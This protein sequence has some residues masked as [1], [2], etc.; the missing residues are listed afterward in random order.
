[1]IDQNPFGGQMVSKYSRKIFGFALSKTAHEHNAQDLAQEILLALHRSLRT[2]KQV[3]NM[4][5]W[6]HTIC[7]YTW[8]NY[9][10]KEKRHWH[11]AD[12]DH[13]MQI[14]DDTAESF[15][16]G[17]DP[18][19]EKLR[20]EIAYLSRL[21]REMTVRYYYDR[22]SI[23]QIAEQMKLATGTVKWHLFEARKKLKEAL[24]LEST[25]EQLS[26]KPIKLMVGHSGTPG[27]NNEPNCYFHSLLTG[28]VCAAIYD[29]ALSIE[30]LARKLGA[31]SAY[32]EDEV[33]KLMKSD[34]I[35]ESGKGKYRTNF[36]IQTM[37]TRRIEGLYFKGKAEE[38]ADGLH[39]CVA[40]VLGEIRATGFHG[41]Q[42]SDN[43]LL[44]T[45]L[46][47]A[48]WKQYLQ[49]QEP[50]YYERI[51]PDERKDGGKYIVDASI[52]YTDDEYRRALT[53]Y[54]IVRKYATNGI[55]SR[56]NDLYGGL[57]MEHWW[58]GLIWRDF[59]SPD[60]TDMGQAVELIDNNAIHTDHDRML[61]SR[62]VKKGFVGME[63]GKLECLVPFFRAEQLDKLHAILE[64][65]FDN[66]G[67][68]QQMN[69]IH[70]DMKAISSQEA[71]SFV[72]KKDV[73]YHA[74]NSGM[75][76]IF[77]VMEYLTRT[78]KIALPEESE[79]NRLTTL[80]W[81]KA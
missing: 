29:K 53:D 52:V 78:G 7:C 63:Q 42:L 64:E 54:E 80:I 3:D 59:D 57:Q 27:P 8:S 31:A 26:F 76:I 74:T 30:D 37:R 65:S 81:R 22:Q 68:K 6:V 24:K 17:K 66:A 40:G 48:I 9:V 41:G 15:M 2:S 18:I 51:S 71:P 4:D 14:R 38:L 60:L 61:I 35:V 47:Y 19:H 50:A 25:T 49:A 43:A 62:L 73:Q 69:Q 21:H 5:A 28:N 16:E 67:M 39:A 36:M 70:E 10:A 23:G 55:K 79:K 56:W 46:P 72:P 13:S 45:L 44:W 34:L 32:V 20:M 11:H 58:A 77:A 12:L 75:T 33:Q 1:M